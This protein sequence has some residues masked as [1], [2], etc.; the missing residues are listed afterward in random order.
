MPLKGFCLYHQQDFDK[1]SDEQQ[2]KLIEHHGKAV[3]IMERQ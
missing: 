2:Q 1:L 3:R